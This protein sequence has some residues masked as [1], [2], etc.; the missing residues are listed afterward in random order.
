MSG[1]CAVTGA[2]IRGVEAV[3]VS[4]EV[5][6]A[7]GIPT[8]AIVGMPD[9]AIQEARERIRAALRACGYSMPT[10][11]VVVSLAPASL[12][13]SGSGFDLPIAL[14]ILAATGQID[15]APVAGRIAVGE[16]SLGGAVRPVPGMLAYAVR[17]RSSGAG[18]V[19]SREAA[20]VATVEGLD[21][22]GVFSLGDFRA[23][24]F[25]AFSSPPPRAVSPPPDF[26][27]VAGH[28]PAKR[29]LQIAAAGS[30]GVLMS[31]P[32][33][34]GK[35]MLAA[36]LPSILPPL[37]NGEALE[38]AVIHSVAGEDPAAI[39]GGARPF[40]SPH[41]SATLAGLVGGGTPVRPGEISLAHNGVLFLD[42]LPLFKPS[43]L[44][45]IRQPIEEGSVTVTRADGSVAMPSRFA[46]VAAANP[47]PCGYLGDPDR[48]C[49]CASAQVRAYQ[50]RIGGPLMD[51]IDI[52]VDVRRI[53]PDEVLRTGAGS[54]SE[55]LRDGVL[56]AREYASWRRARAAEEGG[57]AA[58]G[59]RGGRMRALVAACAMDEKT[60]EFFEKAAL[61]ARMSGRGIMRTLSVARTIADLSEQPSV[62]VGNLCEA[63]SLR[64]RDDAR[65]GAGALP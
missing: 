57:A 59:G 35:T 41:H 10:S 52:R 28:D 60:R 48:A 39:L 11:R 64:A 8:F 4:V 26:A 63:L 53:P 6:V 38:S 1:G 30:H 21:A 54:P 24:R 65:A 50:G 29:A 56:A 42:E 58:P 51:R 62:T 15:P 34:S 33:G 17:A 36:R 12:R 16:L 45:G 55:T 9:L 31:G 25:E 20:E 7:N 3:P 32:P 46:L 14:A 2:T 5:S 23:G 49:S 61:S 27:D 19:C 22:L 43:V 37:T 18:I 13:K 47:C 40:R 44:Q